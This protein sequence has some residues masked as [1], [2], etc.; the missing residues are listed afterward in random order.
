MIVVA[1]IGVLAAIALPAY[2]DYTQRSKLAASLISVDSYKTAVNVCFT[3]TGLLNGC[4]Q[5]T[6]DIPV[7]IAANDNGATINYVDSI[8]IN[9]GIITLTST[10]IDSAANKLSLT[11]TPNVNSTHITWD[12]TGSGCKLNNPARGVDCSGN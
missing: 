11:L 5:N 1:I 3:D 2:S 4:N 12:M 6:N 10:A 7:G 8:T 9:N